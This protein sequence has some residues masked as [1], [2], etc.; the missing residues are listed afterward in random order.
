MSYM[1][2]VKEKVKMKCLLDRLKE[3]PLD[4]LKKKLKYAKAAIKIGERDMKTI[5]TAIDFR[6]SKR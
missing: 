6:L 4:L 2:Y 1:C 3:L 5:Q